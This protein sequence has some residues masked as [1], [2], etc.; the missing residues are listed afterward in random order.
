LPERPA[1][2]IAFPIGG[3]DDGVIRLRLRT[4]ADVPAL[5]AACQDPEIPRWT[6]VPYDYGEER[7]R[8][9]AE[10]AVADQREGRGLH[11]LVVDADDDHLLGSCGIVAIDW[12]EGTCDIGYWAVAEARGRGVIPGAVRLLCGWIF[13]ELP[14]D[15]ITI[16][17]EP[18]N[19]S[20]RRVAEKAGFTFEGVLRSYFVNKG[21]RRD[22]ALYSLLRSELDD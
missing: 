13:D 16:S 12:E 2:G 14:I 18:E 22:A 20:S 1:G 15:R 17:A 11:L 9:W 7:A 3:I 6:R 5:V 19:A 4:D 10:L 8:E 21:T